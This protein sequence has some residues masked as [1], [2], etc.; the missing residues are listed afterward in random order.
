MRRLAFVFLIAIV[1]G[2]VTAK[3][4]RE[5][6]SQVSQATTHKGFSLPELLV[7][8]AVVGLLVGI[9]VPALS[10]ARDSA[11]NAVCLSN[12]RQACTTVKIYA[13]DYQCLPAR[14]VPS[15]NLPE[16]IDMTPATAWRCPQDRKPPDVQTYYS[17]N[18][19][20]PLYMW[21]QSQPAVWNPK[22]AMRR[23]ENDSRLPLYW[24]LQAWH[25][26]KRNAGFY[27]GHAALWVD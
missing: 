19:L 15:M 24:D 7:S 2:L 4:C 9:T 12:I 20:A 23:Y 10:K 1:P 6:V 22:L 14:D 27:D 17:Y 5:A 13:D 26:K 18:Y 16:I 3:P 11:R 21:S 25:S 8:V